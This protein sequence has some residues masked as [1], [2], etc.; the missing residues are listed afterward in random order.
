MV[1]LRSAAN[2]RGLSIDDTMGRRAPGPLG[3][4]DPA[5]AL[6]ALA[7][8]CLSQ[9]RHL[10]GGCFVNVPADAMP[11]ALCA[12]R[13][14]IEALQEDE[15]FAEIEEKLG[16][17]NIFEAIGQIRREVRH[18][19][20]L[21]FLLTPNEAHGLGVAFLSSFLGEVFRASRPEHRALSLSAVDLKSCYVVRELHHVDILCIDQ[22]NNF[23]LAV[24]NKVD[25]DEHSDQLRRYR[26]KLATEYP[27]FHR[28]LVCLSP[29]ARE[30]SDGNSEW[31]PVGYDEVLST[32]E[33]VTE[34]CRDATDKAVA[35]VLDHYARMLRRHIVTDRKLVDQARRLYSKHK[36]TFDFI[37]EN[38]PDDQRSIS[39]HAADHLKK[40]KDLEVV[41][42]VKSMVNFRPVQ[43][44]NVEEFNKQCSD[45]WADLGGSLFFE[46]WN[47]S[48]EIVVTLYIGPSANGTNDT[49]RQRIFDF[50][51][52][53]EHLFVGCSRKFRAKWICVYSESLVGRDVMNNLDVEEVKA[54]LQSSLD[55]FMQGQ[56]V[57]LVDALDREFGEA[58]ANA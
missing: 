44:K 1:C 54:R 27:S 24:E 4:M 5:N 40:H 2:G 47:S 42:S 53:R 56:F 22:A 16:G 6:P 18:S 26:E 49:W 21:A 36:D 43:W 58:D 8:P 39:N 20:F 23:L 41:R 7:L 13:V 28:I 30:P 14:D 57:K 31:I 19:D 46:I 34:K 12:E 50:C 10:K 52:N 51:S 35:L 48:R 37:F 11:D 3:L 29:D 33:T 17:F 15:A 9:E 32:V 25:S 55:H 38:I 45:D